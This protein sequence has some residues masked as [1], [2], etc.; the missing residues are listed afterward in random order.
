MPRARPTAPLCGSGCTSRRAR[1]SP[2]W[3]ASSVSTSSRSKTHPRP[4]AAQAGALRRRCSS[5]CGPRGTSTRP[6]RSTSPSYTSSSG[7]TS[8]S[9]SATGT[10]TSARVRRRMEAEPDLLGGARGDPVRDLRPGGRRLRPVV[11][12][13]ENDI[14]EIEVQ[15]FGGNPGSR[16]APTID[17][18]GDRVPT[19]DQAVAGDPRPA[20]RRE[21]RST[22]RATL[23]AGRAGP[24]H[25]GPGAGSGFRDLLQNILSVNLTP[26]ERRGQRSARRR[27]P[28]TTK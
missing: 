7:R 25:P 19:G 2:R 10:P 13:L 23:P 20:H 9:R 15:V 4:P 18:R 1:S 3:R 24:R 12:G 17:P 11:A 22:M 28:R 5:S 6:R 14:D 21:P 8:S 16:A 26:A 27:W